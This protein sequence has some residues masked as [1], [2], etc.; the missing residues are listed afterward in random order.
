MGLRPTDEELEARCARCRRRR[1]ASQ[2]PPATGLRRASQQADAGIGGG[3][4]EEFFHVEHQDDGAVAGQGGAGNALGFH[5][6][7]YW[8]KILDL[9]ECHLQEPLGLA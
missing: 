5:I 2:N 1:A 7:G 4:A 6:P 9:K 8:D 3:V